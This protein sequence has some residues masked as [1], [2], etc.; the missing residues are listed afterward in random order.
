[1]KHRCGILA[2]LM[3]LLFLPAACL[4]EYACRWE[5]SFDVPVAFADPGANAIVEALNALRLR[6]TWAESGPAFD[7]TVEAG[8]SEN[9]TA[10]FALGGTASHW[11][12]TSPLLG[13]TAL[14]FNNP[15]MIEFGN[16]MNSHLGLPLQAAALLYPYAW[17]DAL[18]AP[19]AA[20][21]DTFMAEEGDRVIPAESCLAFAEA[22]ADMAETDRGF[23]N[24]LLALGLEE[25]GLGAML[26]ELIWELPGLMEQAIPDGVSIRMM[27]GQEVWCPVGRSVPFL[28]R[29]AQS[30]E[31]AAAALPEPLGSA[32][33][34]VRSGDGGLSLSA[35]FGEDEALR[36]TLETTADSARLSIAG[37]LLSETALPVFASLEDGGVSVTLQP[38]GEDEFVL[39]AGI[40]GEEIRLTDG[41]G[42]ALAVITLRQSAWT[43]DAWPDWTA[44]K[45]QGVNLYSLDDSTL[46]PLLEAIAL[47]MVT[48][49]VPLVADA[50]TNA[51]VTLMD[52]FDASGLMT[53]H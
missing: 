2:L 5:L 31:L 6:G 39:C 26:Q 45:V 38:L 40:T 34:S 17:E 36:I 4:A 1:M 46:P 21:N 18:S 8:F 48:G 52:W 22:L 32:M 23:S 44:D 20:F 10:S 11:R 24:L 47:P 19:L 3:A 30:L 37:R 50:P 16:K 42:C 25:D 14:M 15:A 12:L 43:P 29:T 27:G 35:S 7:L 28:V 51:V 41:S 53:A 33:V 13:D 49:L 9:R